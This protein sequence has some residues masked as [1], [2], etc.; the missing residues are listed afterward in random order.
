MQLQQ[1]TRNLNAVQVERWVSLIGGGALLSYGLVSRKTTTL[2]LALVGGG[3]VYHAMRRN[4]GGLPELDEKAPKGEPTS[5]SV[6]YGHG[7]CVEQYVTID[8]P[9]QELYRYWRDL[10]N[11]PR[12][13]SH[14]E[15]VTVVDG[16]HSHW[17]AKA[18]AGM[19][20]EW[21]AV[22]INEVPNEL[23]GW[24]SIPDSDIPNAG[25]VHFSPA[26]GGRG[27]EVRVELQYDPPGGALGAA[28]AKLFGKEP[29][30]TI[31]QDLH[32]FKQL[33]ETGEV[34]TTVGQPHGSRNVLNKF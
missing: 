22:I 33:M 20:V 11:L 12:I 15:S 9:A 26:A 17:V 7:I 28:F 30:Q 5:V 4:R 21:D 25:S 34:A 27:T 31:Y 32:R 10:E 8:R 29:A 16:L 6:P 2:P 3:L 18:P 1:Y 13:M 24:R 14:L 19:K 23:I